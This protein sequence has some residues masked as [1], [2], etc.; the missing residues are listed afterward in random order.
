MFNAVGSILIPMGDM[1]MPC[2]EGKGKGERGRGEAGSTRTNNPKGVSRFE[3][4]AT[5]RQKLLFLCFF[6][7]TARRT[8]GWTFAPM[9][10]TRQGER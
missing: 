10:P 9:G 1:S 8:W 2:V 3:M 5:E 7:A 4:C 6:Q